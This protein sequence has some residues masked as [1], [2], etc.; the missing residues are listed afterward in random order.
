MNFSNAFARAENGDMTAFAEIYEAIYK[1]IY[2]VAY[3]SLANE[4]EAVQAVKTAADEACGEIGKCADADEFN[5]WFLSRL[6]R[7]IIEKYRDYRNNKPV[8]EA[9]APYLKKQMLRLTD[10]ERLTLNIWA[11]FD[12]DEEK[13]TQV[14]G[15]AYEVVK[16]KLQS[17]KTKLSEKL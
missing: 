1:K 9:N 11:A 17:A 15:L 13:I 8:Y 4:K 12:Y 16:K 2:Y 6:C 7:A 5:D 3:Y 10:A 14:T